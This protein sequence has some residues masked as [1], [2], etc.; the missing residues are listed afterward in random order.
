MT[1]V[2]DTICDPVRVESVRALRRVDGSRLEVIGRLLVLATELT[3]APAAALTLVD[4]HRQVF[5]AQVGLPDSVAVQSEVP[6]D[7]SVCRHVVVRERPLMVPDMAA[8][9]AWRD[10]P[11]HRRLGIRAYAGIPLVTGNGMAVGAFCIMDF[12]EHSWAGDAMDRLALLA[13]L[14]TDELELHSHERKDAFRRTWSGV[15]ERPR[16]PGRG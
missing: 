8:D 9:P 2:L 5:L 1:T 15:P 7:W 4:Q 14:A 3:D 6:V 13:Q 12:D 11:A 16:A 10:H